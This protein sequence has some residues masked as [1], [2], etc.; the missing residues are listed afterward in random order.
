MGKLTEWVKL[1]AKEGANIAEFE[2]LERVN[3][4]EGIT[5]KEQALD[6]VKKNAAFTSALD[7]AVTEA[8][9]SHDEKFNRD[10]LP[11]IIKAEREK[12]ESELNPEKTPE[13]KR[14]EEL[15]RR[16]AED[17][18]EKKKAKVA[19]ALVSKAKEL[20]HPDPDAAKRYVAYG[21]RAEEIL[22]ADIEW[23]QKT[24]NSS[25]ESEIKKRY[26][27]QKPPQGSTVDPSRSITRRDFDML[28][29][30]RQMEVAKTFTIED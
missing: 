24:V 25:V 15:E 16:L 26:G 17:E 1:N 21:D 23:L 28:S 27:G 7:Y 22:R 5:T 9:K 3:T 30:E 4:F 11:G 13:Q 18:A 29:P 12:I 2:E 10:K 6:F 19:E 14:I 20:N 8:V